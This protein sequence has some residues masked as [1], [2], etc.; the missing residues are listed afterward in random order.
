MAVTTAASSSELVAT[1]ATSE[2]VV[3]LSTVAVVVTRGTVLAVTVVTVA[4]ATS[5][6]HSV[7]RHLNQL[8]VD[9]LVSFAQHID[10]VAGLVRVGVGE[11]R[12]RGAGV[13]G[14][15]GTSDPVDVILRVGRVVVVDYELHVFDV[16]L[17]RVR[18]IRVVC[19]E[20]RVHTTFVES[21]CVCERLYIT[22]EECFVLLRRNDI[23]DIDRDRGTMQ[24]C[25]FG[26]NVPNRVIDKRFFANRNKMG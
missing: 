19:V 7:L 11:Q 22:E 26:G 23:G 6:A 8:R 24:L 20:F 13:V 1:A 15:P 17:F 18:V 25:K 3:A 16:C 4:V 21:V 14:A 10:E 9:D 5:A 2:P 12:V